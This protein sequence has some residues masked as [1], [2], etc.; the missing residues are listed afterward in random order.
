MSIISADNKD[1]MKEASNIQQN[2]AFEADQN[3]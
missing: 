2:K 3:M 1:Q